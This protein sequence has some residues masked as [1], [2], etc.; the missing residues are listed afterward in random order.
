MCAC[1]HAGNL[2]KKKKKEMEE[3]EE[4][5]DKGKEK[6][7]EE[8]KGKEEKKSDVTTQVKKEISACTGKP[9]MSLPNIFPS[10]LPRQT[11]SWLP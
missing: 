11:L 10:F 7:E 3:E 9:P 2:K 6:K 4:E 8:N 5:A 1:T